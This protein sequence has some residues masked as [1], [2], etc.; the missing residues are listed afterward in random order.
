MRLSWIRNTPPPLPR[1]TPAFPYAPFIH[2]AVAP[3]STFFMHAPH[4]SGWLWILTASALSADFPRHWFYPPLVSLESARETARRHQETLPPLPV[5][6]TESCVGLFSGTSNPATS[7]WIQIDFES[8]YPLD[9]VAIVPAFAAT[10]WGYGF[11]RE[12][13]VELSLTP[14]FGEAHTLHLSTAS[15]PPQGPLFLKAGN[16]PARYL[17][18][19]ATELA[20]HPQAASRG[21]FCLGEVFAFSEGRNVALHRPVTAPGATESRPTWS[22]KNIVDGSTALSLPLQQGG[23]PAGNGWHS[24]I[25]KSPDV[26]QWVQVDLGASQPIDE[27]RLVPARPIDFM[28]RPGFGFPPG[29]RIE[30][31]DSPEFEHPIL[32]WET[33]DLPNPGGNA[34]MIRIQTAVA[35]RYLRVTATRLWQR[36]EDYVFALSELQIFS[37]SRN[38]ALRKPVTSL[39][40]TVSGSWSPDFLV[41][42]RSSTGVLLDLESWLRALAERATT[43]FRIESLD[44]EIADGRRQ[45]DGRASAAFAV[46]VACVLVSAGVF[47]IHV[48]RRER[49]RLQTLREQIAR[50]L[51]D[52]IGS[53]LGSI[54]LMSE[55]AARSSNSGTLAEIHRLASDAAA[56]MR[57]I[58][59][60]V[61]ESGN[62]DLARLVDALRS[63]AA[64][65]LVEIPFAFSCALPTPAPCVSLAVHREVFLAFKEAIHNISRHAHATAVTIRIHLDSQALHLQIEDNGCGFDP[66]ADHRGSGLANMRHRI[67]SIGGRI[68]IES[69]QDSGTRLFFKVPLAP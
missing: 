59:W 11:P 29:F 36:H 37:G 7:R 69:T 13:R 6:E 17:R 66:E 10:Q 34:V 12:F 52:D 15:V 27:V 22:P 62:P 9:S 33:D 39:E 41:D 47:L 2:A 45:A 58:L 3:F 51:H 60:M 14:D 4:V 20:S 54:A 23:A 65:A 30:A 48:R 38:V 28:D 5:P 50:D 24:A 63:T 49:R 46:L 18:I 16:I 25:H 43:D 26:P 53:S 61:R 21:I 64:Q 31:S 19:T 40:Q 57:G 67:T 35:G 55:M 56:S 8:V 32:L 1:R 68:Q 42:N 44:R